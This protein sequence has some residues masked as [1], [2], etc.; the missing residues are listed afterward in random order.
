M[1]RR[2]LCTLAL[3]SL[4]VLASGCTR[5]ET[6]NTLATEQASTQ[7]AADPS[8][9][10]VEQTATPATAANETM[11]TNPNAMPASAPET[12]IA[13][14]DGETPG[15]RVDVYE[16]KRTSGDTVTLKFALVNNGKK[17][18]GG[19]DFGKAAN[20]YDTVADIHL[21]EPTERTQYAVMRDP[22]N[23]CVCSTGVGVKTGEQKRYWA[24][25]P[26]PPASSTK[27][28]VVVPHF[29]PI[30]DVPVS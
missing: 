10:I 16:L 9:T 3:V 6:S 27:L 29:E 11:A 25:F 17:E 22:D 21:L 13:H 23:K 20:D 15:T 28:T 5:S 18:L 26:A 2:V 7:S 4:L 30:E 14:G 8:A 24:K 19:Y 12:V 1:A